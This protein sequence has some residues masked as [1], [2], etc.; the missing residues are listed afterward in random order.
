MIYIHFIFMPKR[1]KSF[2][3]DDDVYDD[4]PDYNELNEDSRKNRRKSKNK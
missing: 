1:I 4:E 2:N 3:F